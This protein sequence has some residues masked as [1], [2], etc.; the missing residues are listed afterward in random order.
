MIILEGP[1]NSGKSTLGVTLAKALET[2]TRHSIRPAPGSTPLQCLEHSARQL[3]PQRVILDR[4]FAISE[5]IYGPICRGQS[6]ME[7]HT[8]EA[9]L[10][11]Y[12]RPY[13]II[14]CRPRSK[15]I[16]DNKGRDQMPGVL[17]N[18]QKIIAAYDRIMLDISRFSKCRVIQY[19]W[20]NRTELP[21]L[22]AEAKSHLLKFDQANWSSTW[23][24]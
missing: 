6:A 15:T 1:D 22:I 2:T 10:D 3:R 8:R 14:Y 16:L 18:H 23:M 17:E 4:V 12:Q 5:S 19:D 11:L 9:I 24:S 13:L 20:Q 21:S 7:R